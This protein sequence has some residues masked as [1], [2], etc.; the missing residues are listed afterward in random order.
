MKLWIFGDSYVSQSDADI[1]KFKYNHWIHFLRKNLNCTELEVRAHPGAANEW[2]YFQ[3]FTSLS[4]I[5][6][7]DYVVFVSSQMNRR[8]FF[9]NDVGSS[10]YHINDISMNTISQEEKTALKYYAKYLDNPIIARIFFENMCNS[11]HYHAIKNKL[12][13]ILL[14]GFEGGDNGFPVNGKYKVEGSLFNIGVNEIKGKTIESWQ[15]FISKT[16]QG[17]DPRNGHLSY[18]NHTIMSKKITDTF[19]NNEP[20]KLDQGFKEDFL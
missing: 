3:F 5:K 7:D 6:S 14:P 10:N 17:Q 20:L 9:E 11:I 4:E 8:W 12:N 1:E 18:E 2:I 13:L 19:L 15:H 16:H